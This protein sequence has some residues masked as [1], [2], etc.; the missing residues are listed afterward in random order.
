MSSDPISRLI[1]ELG[2]LPGVGQKTATRLAFHLLRA[3]DSQV[4]DLSQALLDVKEKIRLCS[5]C[6]NLT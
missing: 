3:P 4:R 5:L 2:K 6:G 1:R